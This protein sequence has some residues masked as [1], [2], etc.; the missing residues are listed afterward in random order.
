[1]E[2]E[3]NAETKFVRGNQVFLPVPLRNKSDEGLKISIDLKNNIIT[4]ACRKDNASIRN[5]VV[6]CTGFEAN[7]GPATLPPITRPSRPNR[8]MLSHP[9]RPCDP[10]V[11]ETMYEPDKQS[12]S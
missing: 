5:E 8:E 3:A 6:T 1:M 7:S 4:T 10:P 12:I 2:Q 9:L 11:S